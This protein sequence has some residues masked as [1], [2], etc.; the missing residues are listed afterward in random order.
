[1]ASGTPAELRGEVGATVYL[2][3]TY[4]ADDFLRLFSFAQLEKYAGDSIR[5][6]P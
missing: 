2:K 5:K 6:F 3:N 4:K 1:M